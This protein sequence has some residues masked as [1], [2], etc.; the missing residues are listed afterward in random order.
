MSDADGSVRVPGVLW[1]VT[2][3][4]HGNP[5]PVRQLQDSLT[6]LAFLH[7]FDM[8]VRFAGDTAE[9]RYW[10]EGQDCRGV[11]ERA[12][13]LWDEHRAD[14]GL[15]AWPVVGVEVLD[16]F[17]FR[18]RWTVDNPLAHLLAPGVLP[19]PRG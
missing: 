4:L 19:F 13:A 8:A 11:V 15:P 1:H 6:E 12:L 16:R 5:S 18:R 10:D 17:T 14:L 3:T 9:L 2:V 7:P